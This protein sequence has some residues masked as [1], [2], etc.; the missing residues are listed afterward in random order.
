LYQQSL[1]AIVDVTVKRDG[2]ELKF[3]M[4]VIE[5]DDDPQRFADMV[6]PER[7]L[8]RRLGIL[9]IEITDKLSEMLPDL[10]HDYGVVVAARASD[11]PGSVLEPGDVIYEMNKTPTVSI[12]A[13]RSVL[14]TLK[15]GDTAV[16]QVQ[17]GTKLRYIAIDME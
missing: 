4:P 3:S 14:D 1:T 13:L 16:L 2:K 5:R 10:R 12:K 11:A 6:N 7:N 15:P 17:R 9:A 8:I